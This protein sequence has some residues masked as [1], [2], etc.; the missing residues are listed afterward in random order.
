MEQMNLSL[1]DYY[2]LE[3]SKFMIEYLETKRSKIIQRGLLSPYE[4]V[5]LDDIDDEITYWSKNM[6]KIYDR[7][8][9]Y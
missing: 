8:Y 5:L 9:D 6:D 4:D 1:D 3:M 2:D 7:S